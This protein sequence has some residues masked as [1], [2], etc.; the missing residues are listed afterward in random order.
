MECCKLGIRYVGA[1]PCGLPDSE[2][3][4][5]FTNYDR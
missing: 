2:Q 4:K 3:E 1:N 5:C